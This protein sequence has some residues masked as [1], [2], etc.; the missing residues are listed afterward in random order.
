VKGRRR[1]ALAASMLLPFFVPAIAAAEPAT[2]PL[3]EIGLGIGGVS[4]PAY[5]GSD[6]RQGM[7]LPT[8]YFV[9]RGDL[10]KADR[11]GVRGIFFES[12]RV[13]LNVSGSASI[14]VDSDDVRVRK[15]M[16]D[17]EPTLELGPSLDFNLWRSSDRRRSLDL[18]LPVRYAF[19]AEA[20]P[21]SA[22]WQ[23]TPRLNLDI[24]DPGA[25]RGWNLGLLTGPVYG[26]RR[27]HQYFYG[28][29][30]RYATVTRNAYD[31]SGGYAGW[32]VLAALSKRFPAYWIG[33][34]VRYDSLRGAV[35]DDS[36]LVASDRY[37][38]GGIAIA[39]IIGE[40]SI[41]VPAND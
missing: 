29:G 30:E 6:Q 21:H 17:L 8:P 33:G 2:Q 38:A 16:P 32:Q 12:D 22:G 3:W 24:V 5:R 27:Q 10:F 1:A 31:A 36:P 37:L 41:R 23:F 20:D 15:G 11:D 4:F 9:Y 7:V 18:R 39:W 14:P 35:F 40:S 13:D 25:F 19:T 28:V 34:F 26:T